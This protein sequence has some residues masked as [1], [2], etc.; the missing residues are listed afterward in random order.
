ML[1]QQTQKGGVVCGCSSPLC[2]VGPSLFVSVSVTN[3]FQKFWLFRNTELKCLWNCIILLRLGAWL[4]A[5]FL[6]NFSMTSL[7]NIFVVQ[8]ELVGTPLSMS[9][10]ME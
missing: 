1:L 3:S 9:G 7:V 4:I 6:I 5:I 2:N 10:D 8:G